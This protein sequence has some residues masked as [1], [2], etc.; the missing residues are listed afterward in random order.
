MPPVAGVFRSRE[1]ARNAVAELLRAGFAREQITV[2]LPGSEKAERALPGAGSE[3]ASAAGTA[4]GGVLGAALGAAG[5]FEFGLGIT[6]LIPG[7]GPVFAAG[8]AGAAILGAGGL[9]AGARIGAEAGQAA[10]ATEGLSA[11]EIPLYEEALRQGRSIVVL[12]PRGDLDERLGSEILARVG[13]E[14][15]DFT[16]RRDLANLS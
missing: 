12:L 7:V 13:G 11:R 16:R 9:I 4:I 1:A 2:V 14:S 15:I 6:A 3:N 5:G 10:A 8:I